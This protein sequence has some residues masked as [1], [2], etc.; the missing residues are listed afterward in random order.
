M[1]NAAWIVRRKIER[2]QRNDADA[3]D[4]DVGELETKTGALIREVLG[5]A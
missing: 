3:R 4:E 2:E 1:L 5:L